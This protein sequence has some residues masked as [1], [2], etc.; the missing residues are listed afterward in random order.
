M[1]WQGTRA[2][3]VGEG[4][5]S[6]AILNENLRDNIQYNRDTTRVETSAGPYNAYWT[7]SI[8]PNNPH[9]FADLNPVTFKKRQADTWL[10]MRFALQAWSDVALTTFHFGLYYTGGAHG[11]TAVDT[12]DNPSLPPVKFHFNAAE[13]QT[14]VGLLMAGIEKPATYTMQPSAVRTFGGGVLTGDVFLSYTL[15]AFEV[16]PNDAF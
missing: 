7:A 10:C 6:A 11:N 13:Q 3:T 12:L 2:W 15:E 9:A 1:T 8:D 16:G 5:W 14:I 4:P